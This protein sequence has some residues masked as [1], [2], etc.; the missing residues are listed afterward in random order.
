VEAFTLLDLVANY[1]L[2]FAPGAGL[3]LS[4]QNIFDSDYRSFP[5]VPTIGR[6]AMLRLRYQF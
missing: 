5:G 1:K 4:V 2:P 6:F 3:D